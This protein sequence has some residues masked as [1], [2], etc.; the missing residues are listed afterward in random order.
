MPVK[1]SLF[2]LLLLTTSAFS[3]IINGRVSSS[4]YAFERMESATSSTMYV[5]GYQALNLSVGKENIFLR[6]SLNFENAYSNQLDQDSRLRFYSLYLDVRNLFDIANIKLGRQPITARIGGGNFDG[7]SAKFNYLDFAFSGFYGGN[8]P[9]YQKLEFTSDFAKDNVYGFGISTPE[10]YNFSLGV[11]YYSKN[12]AAK[13]YY[14]TRLDENFNPIT[15]L[16]RRNSTNFSFVA[17]T[18]NYSV[19]NLVDVR[20]RYEYDLNFKKSSLFEADLSY[21]VMNDLDVQ[22]YYNIREP[23]IRYNSIFSVFDYGNTSEIEIGAGYKVFPDYIISSRFGMTEYKDESSGRISVGLA[24]P[25][26]T[27]NYRNGFGYAGELNSFSVGTSKS[28][29]DGM[30]TPSLAMSYVIYKL[31][32]DDPEQ[33][34]T[35]VLGGINYRPF[36]KFSADLQVQYLNNKIYAND[37]RFLLKLNHWFNADLKNVF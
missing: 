13:E 23:R 25:Y 17:G 35:S 20:T 14:A 32:A 1:N 3:Q 21:N 29:L 22:A 11:D 2:I 34:L 5:R 15:L 36:N 12:S 6:T 27:I 19:E 16:I 37:L 4:V 26:G 33:N 10:F 9:P 18:L 28:F 24:T 8:V 31:S 7:I 30:I